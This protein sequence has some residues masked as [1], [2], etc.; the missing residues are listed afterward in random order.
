MYVYFIKAFGERDLVRIKIGKAK[1]PEERL[2]TLQTGSPVKLKLIGVIKCKS[3]AHAYHVEKLAHDRFYKQRKRGEWF[4]LSLK[5]IGGLEDLIASAAQ[6]QIQIK[7]RDEMEALCAYNQ[8]IWGD[9]WD[10]V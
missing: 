3:S 2:K 4:R 1:D 7:S 5:H 6:N 9:S 8:V 10:D